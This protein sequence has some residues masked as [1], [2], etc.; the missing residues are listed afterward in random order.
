MGTGGER[1]Q[2]TVLGSREDEIHRETSKGRVFAGCLSLICRQRGASVVRPLHPF[3]LFCL[4]GSFSP[5]LFLSVVIRDRF[6]VGYN[7]VVYSF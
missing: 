5:S 3:T 1:L 4:I 2:W 7:K 6:T